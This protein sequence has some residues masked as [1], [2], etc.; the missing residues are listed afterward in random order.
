MVSDRERWDARHAL[1][2]GEPA[3][4]P[5]PFVAEVLAELGPGHGRRAL[6]LA[7]GTG[8][9]ALVAAE[10][11][12]A[13]EAWDVSPVALAQLLAH[14][15]ARGVS[16]A[17][18]EVDLTQL[19]PD[20]PPAGLVM[21]V[22]F[23]DRD[24]FPRLGS[25]LLPGGSLVISTFTVDFPGPRPSGRFRLERGELTRDLPGLERVRAVEGGGRAGL[26]ARR[27][28]DS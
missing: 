9:H 13:V 23:L 12:F 1:G 5:D 19:P 21:V 17:T 16:V 14:A 11:G 22:D 2:K 28:E 8:R 4:S 18:R 27:R 3:H 25:L 6:D 20:T 10:R 7:C 26:W 15:S 24:L